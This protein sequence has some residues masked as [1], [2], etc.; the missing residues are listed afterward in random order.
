LQR[1]A[2]EAQRLELS[3]RIA[4]ACGGRFAIGSEQAAAVSSREEAMTPIDKARWKLLS[5]L[6]DQLLDLEPAERSARLDQMRS[7]DPVLAAELEALLAANTAA[8]RDHF[9]EGSVPAQAQDKTI[10][11]PASD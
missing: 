5:P 11:G 10:E 1:I 4:V 3:R 6:L 2:S 8:Q 9:L 7:A